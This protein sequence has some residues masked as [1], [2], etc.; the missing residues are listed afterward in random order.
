M[1]LKNMI[2]VGLTQNPGFLKRHV[3]ALSKY[4]SSSRDNEPSCASNG[5]LQYTGKY[6]N[7]YIQITISWLWTQG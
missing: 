7:A 5:I 4:V 6:V 1:Y 2:I 3:N